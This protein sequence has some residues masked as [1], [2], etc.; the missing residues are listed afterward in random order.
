MRISSVLALVPMLLVGC[1]KE[2]S[3][4]DLLAAIALA[5]DGK[6]NLQYMTHHCRMTMVPTSSGV[7]V[8]V[9]TAERV[10]VNPGEIG[11]VG[12]IDKTAVFRWNPGTGELTQ[13]K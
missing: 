4:S 7:I 12:D 10:W 8:V 9:V 11:S 6:C 5:T 2:A 1:K 13:T 3:A